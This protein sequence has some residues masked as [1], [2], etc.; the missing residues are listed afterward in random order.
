MSGCSWGC[1]VSR[2]SETLFPPGATVRLKKQ[3][4][5][6][7]AGGRVCLLSCLK[8]VC[9]LKKKK[10][11]KPFHTLLAENVMCVAV[12]LDQLLSDL[13]KEPYSSLTHLNGALSQLLI[14]L[15][16][17]FISLHS[18]SHVQPSPRMVSVVRR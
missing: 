3:K 6:W 4:L 1:A 8:M 12:G 7:K 14:Q 16:V 18:F 15:F 11:K 13:A 2:L 5:V 10:K 17:N 9:M